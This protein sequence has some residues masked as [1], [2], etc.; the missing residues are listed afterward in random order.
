MPTH[1]REALDAWEQFQGIRQRAEGKGRGLT[2]KELD[3]RDRLLE[4]IRLGRIEELGISRSAGDGSDMPRVRTAANPGFAAFLR[5]GDV[6]EMRMGSDREARALGVG[7]GS[8]GGYL[9]PSEFRRELIE[10]MVTFGGVR[11]VASHVDTETGANL[12]WPT[13]NDTANVGAILAENTQVAEQ[14]VV[15]GT[16]DLDAYMYTSKLVRVSLQLIQDSGFDVEQWLQ[17]A[18]ATRIARIQNTHFTTG[19]GTAQPLGIATSPTTGVTAAS[20]TAVTYDEL[21][22]LESSVDPEYIQGP[23]VGFMMNTTTLA[24]IRKLKDTTN[25]PL[26]EPDV[27]AG[28]PR[29]LLGHKV[30]VNQAMSNMAASTKPVLFGNFRAAYVTRDAGPMS[31]ARLSERYADFLQVGFLA[32]L[33]SDGIVQDASAYKSLVMA[34]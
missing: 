28:A 3:E 21:V 33:R 6:S 12:P 32:F 29:S 23:G 16:A 8:A 24:T 7:T 10:T 11:A 20:Q 25:R 14:D 26:L 13:V 22:S 4:V 27:Q 34:A 17:G 19:T 30:F 5:S 1:T 15:L 2:Q 9:V 31:V 18:L